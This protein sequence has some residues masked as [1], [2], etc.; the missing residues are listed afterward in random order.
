MI[1]RNNNNALKRLRGACAD[2]CSSLDAATGQ[3]AP[4]AE[5]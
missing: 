3:P 5:V 2:A 4:P 1:R